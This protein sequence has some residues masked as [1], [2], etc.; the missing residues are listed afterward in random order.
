MQHI[1]QFIA[2]E[3]RLSLVTLH[4]YPLQRCFLPAASP[5]YPTIHNLLLPSASAGLAQSVARYATL[6]HAHGISLR[7]DELNS[8]SCGG[9]VG[10]S[11]T[12]ASALWA[13]DAAFQMARVGVD[14]VNIHTFPGATYQLFNFVRE[15]GAWI[16]RVYPEYYGL[17]MFAQAAPAGSRLLE[18][19]GAAPAGVE[20]WATRSPDGTTRVVLIN[21][22]ASGARL[23]AVRAGDTGELAT[24]ERLTAPGLAAK[25]GVTI[26]GQTF[27]MNTTTGTPSGNQDLVSIPPVTGAYVVRV[28]A[29]SAALLTI[30]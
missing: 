25:T 26:G 21:T 12:F 8:V 3:P 23:V 19:S 30:P 15:R 20:A 13:L 1:G 7:I 6:A 5:L 29:A 28:P 11:D 4:R 18:S 2:D 16:A 17:M 27:G 24:L 9:A 10:V 22:G 14:G